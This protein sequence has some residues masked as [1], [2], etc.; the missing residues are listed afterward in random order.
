MLSTI[1]AICSVAGNM[2]LVYV[3]G[4]FVLEVCHKSKSSKDKTNMNGGK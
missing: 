3:A 4:L 2:C 1:S